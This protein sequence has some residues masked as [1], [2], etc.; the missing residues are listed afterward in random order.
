MNKINYVN[1]AVSLVLF[2]VTIESG[3]YKNYDQL[4]KQVK[5][6]YIRM[7]TLS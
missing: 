1:T 5:L 7:N 2:T 3:N 6:D 4:N